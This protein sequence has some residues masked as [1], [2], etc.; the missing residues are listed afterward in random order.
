MTPAAIFTASE[1]G[2]FERSTREHPIYFDYLFE[3][4]EDVTINLP[5]GWQVSSVPKAQD[6]DVKVVAYSLKVERD[7]GTLHLKRRLTIGIGFL[8]QKYYPTLRTFFQLVRAGD[9]EQVALQPEEIHV[10]N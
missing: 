5:A 4:S 9:G 10:S 6:Q 8:G 1:R 7:Q 3:K 2:V